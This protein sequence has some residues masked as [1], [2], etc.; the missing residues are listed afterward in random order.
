[1]IFGF[2]YFWMLRGLGKIGRWE[3]VIFNLFLGLLGV[4][5]G[6]LYICVFGFEFFGLLVFFEI[7]S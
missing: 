7:V 1:M 3:K 4:L 6:V 2:I 5:L